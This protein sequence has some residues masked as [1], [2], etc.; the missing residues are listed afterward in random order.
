LPN[1]RT[2]GVQLDEMF[3]TEVEYDSAAAKGGVKE[4]DEIFKVD[5][6]KVADRMELSRAL[7]AGGPKKVVAVLRDGKEVELNISWEAPAAE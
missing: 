5:G 2:L 6:A 1:R 4:G 7:R 3:V